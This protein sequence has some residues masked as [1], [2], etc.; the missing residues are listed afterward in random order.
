MPNQLEE[1]LANYI[2]QPLGEKRCFSVLLPLVWSENQWQVL[3]QV[4]SESI[5]QPGESHFL[6]EE[7]RKEKHHS[8]QLFGRLWRN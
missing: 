7:L 2:P 4:R 6:V 8:K 3:Y 1:L 5:S